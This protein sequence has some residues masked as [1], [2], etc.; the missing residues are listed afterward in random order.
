MKISENRFLR[1][2]TFVDSTGSSSKLFDPFWPWV[3]VD[4]FPVI[5]WKL[6]KTE[7]QDPVMSTFL[8]ST[9]SGWWYAAP[10]LNG[11]L[12]LLYA[13]SPNNLKKL[14]VLKKEFLRKILTRHYILN[15]GLRSLDFAD[16]PPQFYASTTLSTDQ[17]RLRH[18]QIIF[19]RIF[20]PTE[21]LLPA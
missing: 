15:I 10:S 3:R 6:F 8:E 2:H 11:G 19:F 9:N 18:N 17:K 5:H 7:R 12:S 13:T 21:M 1:C 14:P 4:H 20:L 16:S